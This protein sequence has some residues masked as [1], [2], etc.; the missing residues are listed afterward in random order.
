MKIN[1]EYMLSLVVFVFSFIAI[2][3]MLQPNS[4]I[5]GFAATPQSEYTTADLSI[6]RYI[7]TAIN[8]TPINFTYGGIVPGYWYNASNG[9]YGEGFPAQIILYWETNTDTNTTYWGDD[10]FCR[11][12]TGCDDSFVNRFD[13]GNLTYNTSFV[14]YTTIALHQF[15][16][17][18]WGFADLHIVLGNETQI[19]EVSDIEIYNSTCPC[20]EANYTEYVWYR[21]Y[22]PPGVYTGNYEANITFKVMD[23][24]GG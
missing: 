6:N 12:G 10:Y 9:T 11:D 16:H 22:V 15:E 21:L 24:G 20:G 17:Y 23:T 8:F 1:F 7:N 3:G 4:F 18:V 2:Y 19:D 14:N 5:T 13:V